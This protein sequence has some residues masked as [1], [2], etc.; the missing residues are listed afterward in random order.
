[1]LHILKGSLGEPYE[2]YKL[3]LIKFWTF[4]GVMRQKNF[5]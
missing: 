4:A 2:P 5:L 3:L 1:M